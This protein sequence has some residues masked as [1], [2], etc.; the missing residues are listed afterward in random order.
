MFLLDFEWAISPKINH[1]CK[2]CLQSSFQTCESFPFKNSNLTASQF[3]TLNIN[4]M[5]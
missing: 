5:A 1:K 3:L 4:Y 2:L